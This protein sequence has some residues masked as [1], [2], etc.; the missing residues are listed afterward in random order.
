MSQFIVTLVDPS[1]FNGI[2]RM[3]V[4]TSFVKGLFERNGVAFIT[5]ETRTSSYKTIAVQESFDKISN[6]MIQTS[7]G[8]M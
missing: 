6:I 7:R 5:V 1:E 3:V 8:Y 2:E 4:D